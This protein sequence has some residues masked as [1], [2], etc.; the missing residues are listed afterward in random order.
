MVEWR[1]KSCQ[2][3]MLGLTLILLDSAVSTIGISVSTS[4]RDCAAAS[5][6]S[7]FDASIG[8]AIVHRKEP[9]FCALSGAWQPR[10]SADRTSA[11]RAGGQFARR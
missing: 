7:F 3:F 4:V 5:E 9:G 8:P 6:S 10:G 2:S 1:T 11:G